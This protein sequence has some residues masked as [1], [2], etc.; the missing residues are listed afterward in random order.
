MLYDLLVEPASKTF[1]VP[2]KIHSEVMSTFKA[3]VSITPEIVTLGGSATTN[4][5]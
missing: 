2:V 4:F 3:L 5:V 1:K